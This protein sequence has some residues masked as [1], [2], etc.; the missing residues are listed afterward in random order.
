MNYVV[1]R[2]DLGTCLIHLAA[3]AGAGED[4]HQCEGQSCR[5]PARCDQRFMEKRS[6]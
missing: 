1:H 4:R 5:N 3:V 6:L 2:V